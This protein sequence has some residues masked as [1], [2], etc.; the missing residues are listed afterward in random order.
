MRALQQS[1]SLLLVLD[2]R[3]SRDTPTL[4]KK[5]GFVI[6]NARLYQSLPIFSPQTEMV[7]WEGFISS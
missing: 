7:S 6:S 4:K 1:L 3:C 2:V 5:P